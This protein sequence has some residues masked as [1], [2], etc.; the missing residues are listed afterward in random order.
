LAKIDGERPRGFIVVFAA[1]LPEGCASVANSVCITQL[2]ETGFVSLI[3][4][5]GCGIGK[6]NE[7]GSDGL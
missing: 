5:N 7:L 1:R 6:A 3:S 2:G 4:S